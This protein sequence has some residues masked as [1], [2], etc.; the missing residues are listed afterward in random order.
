MLA[1]YYGRLKHEAPN[2]DVIIHNEFP[3]RRAD[4]H[5]IHSALN[6]D[7]YDYDGKILTSVVYELVRRGYDIT[8]LRFSI[9]MKEARIDE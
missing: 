7:R 1:V 5:F 3:A 9:E 4:A 6:T 2:G 8:T